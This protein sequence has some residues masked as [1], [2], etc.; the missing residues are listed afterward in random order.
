V[1]RIR[2]GDGI[3]LEHEVTQL[4]RRLVEAALE[5]TKDNLTD[6]AKLLGISFRQIRYKVRQL[7]LR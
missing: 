3:D 6:A 5:Q 7:G 1:K 2:S 4:E